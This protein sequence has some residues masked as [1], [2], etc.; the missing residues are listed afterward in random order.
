MTIHARS[1]YPWTDR[2]VERR[3]VERRHGHV[4]PYSDRDSTESRRRRLAREAVRRALEL[5]GG[6][7]RI[8][9]QPAMRPGSA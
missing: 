1:L 5:Y 6:I 8:A 2:R 7:G 3:G 9:F 4:A